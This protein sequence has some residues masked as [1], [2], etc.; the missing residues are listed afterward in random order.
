MSL[1]NF[2]MK[3]NMTTIILNKYLFM[4]ILY[5]TDFFVKMTAEFQIPSPLVPSRECHFVRYCKQHSDGTWAVVDVSIDSLRPSPAMRCRRRPSGCLIHEMPNGYS[6]VN[7]YPWCLY[8]MECQF[9]SDYTILLH[10]ANLPSCIHTHTHTHSRL[11][12]SNM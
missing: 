8:H 7:K 11:H 3:L 5:R 12:G 10:P 1:F 6:Q 9:V 2:K 4:Y